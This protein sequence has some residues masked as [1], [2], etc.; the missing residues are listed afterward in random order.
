MKDKIINLISEVLE[1]SV[2]ENSTKDNTDNWDSL[3]HVKLILELQDTFD[4]KISTKD[5]DKLLSA[6]EII[7]YISKRS[8]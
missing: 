4:I 7:N 1:T 6:K 5:I 2:D 8:K 3:N